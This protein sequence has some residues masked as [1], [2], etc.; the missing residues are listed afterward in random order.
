MCRQVSLKANMRLQVAVN[1]YRHLDDAVFVTRSA[2]VQNALGT[3]GYG[4]GH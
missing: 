2:F 4:A 3:H 1:L